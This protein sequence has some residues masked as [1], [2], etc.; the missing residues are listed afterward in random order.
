MEAVIVHFRGS[1][2]TQYKNHMILKAKES[3]TRE[4]AKKLVNK[5][6]TWTSPAG[7]EIHGQIKAEHGN[8]GAVRAIF[9]RGLPGQSLSKK[10]KIL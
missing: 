7:K 10:V 5:R 9:E 2:K 6:V 3:N 8:K 4:E 1:Q